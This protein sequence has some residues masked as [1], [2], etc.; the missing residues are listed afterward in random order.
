[1]FTC[2]LLEVRGFARLGQYLHLYYI[3]VGWAR[4]IADRTGGVK[5]KKGYS[6]SII[7]FR[8]VFSWFWGKGE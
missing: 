7:I 6:G 2:M 4:A 5:D 8:D 1:M 3:E